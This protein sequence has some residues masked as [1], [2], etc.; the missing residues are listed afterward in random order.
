MDLESEPVTCPYCGEA[1][2]VSAEAPGLGFEEYVED[3]PVCCRPWRVQ[4]TRKGTMVRIRL[5]RED[6]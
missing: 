4:V 2:D 6:D 3:C 1:V 5:L